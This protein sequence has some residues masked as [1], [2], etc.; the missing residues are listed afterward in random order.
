MKE[1]NVLRKGLSGVVFY[2]TSLKSLELVVFKLSLTFNM[3][4][5]LNMSSA[6]WPSHTLLPKHTEA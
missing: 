1:E 3:F 6:R 5:I 2:L 4:K